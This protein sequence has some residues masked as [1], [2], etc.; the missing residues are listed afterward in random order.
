MRKVFINGEAFCKPITGVIRVAVDIINELDTM[1]TKEDGFVLVVPKNTNYLPE[2]KNIEIK[3]LD[4]ELKR[5]YLW[6]QL[7]FQKAVRKEKALSLDFSNTCP[8]MSPGV[9]YLH[10]IYCKLYPNDY[11]G[12]KEKLIM[13][14]NLVNYKRIVKKAKAIIAVS[15]YTKQTII[16]TYHVDGDRIKVIYNGLSPAYLKLEPDYSII[17][18]HPEL[19]E[20]G[21]YFTLGT[22]AVRKNLKWIA[23][24]AQL[25]PDETFAISGG[26]LTNLVPPELEKLKTLK[27]VVLLGYL[28]D[29]EVK[30]MMTKCKAF[31]LPSYFEGFG[32][33]P[34]EA[35]SCGSPIIISDRTSLPEIY[36]KTAHYIDPD[37]NDVNLDELLSEPVEDPASLLER[38]TIN[39]CTSQLLEVIQA[40]RGL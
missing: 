30:A 19:K 11:H 26:I 36:G 12:L 6:E 28:S 20:K 10:D 31:I 7:P 25:Y 4:Y 38:Y 37:K 1:V 22:L 39:N 3:V 40:T 9:E 35:L 5:F 24:H 21:F 34:L 27:N 15:E 18:K 13:L 2:L 29:A 17:Q 23:D 16:D 8:L 32:I 14:Y 33:P